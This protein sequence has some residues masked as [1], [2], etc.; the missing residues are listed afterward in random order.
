MAALN[1][2]GWRGSAGNVLA[3]GLD[4]LDLAGQLGGEGLLQRLQLMR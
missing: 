1:T 3:E 2:S 4:L